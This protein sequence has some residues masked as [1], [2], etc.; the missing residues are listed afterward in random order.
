MSAAFTSTRLRTLRPN[1]GPEHRDG[2]GSGALAV[3]A[4]GQCSPGSP[5]APL[6]IKPVLGLP[7][8]A[9]LD[10]DMPAFCAVVQH[11]EERVR[12]YPEEG[13]HGDCL[14]YT[15]TLPTN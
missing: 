14:L 2:R 4:R 13:R 11:D 9:A 5:P 3:R 1:A 7:S 15:L 6:P 8:T 10:V 12:P